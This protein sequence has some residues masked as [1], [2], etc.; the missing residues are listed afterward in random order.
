[1]KQMTAHGPDRVWN[2]TDELV[3]DVRSFLR[4]ALPDYM[5]PSAFVLLDALPLTPNGK[6][7]YRALPAPELANLQSEAAF[8][9]P[10]TPAEEIVAGVLADVLDIEQVGVD[11]NF[12]EIGG[13]SLLATQVVAQLRQIFGMDVPLRDFLKTPTVDGLVATLAELWGGRA[14]VEEIALTLREVEQLSADEMK[15]LL[16]T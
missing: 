12:F 8:V 9:A 1:L 10:R 3:G 11:S 13:N 15:D 2:T 5:I 6:V 16:S 7:D 4:D 14:T